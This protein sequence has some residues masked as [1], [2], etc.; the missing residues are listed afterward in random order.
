M[1]TTQ[2]SDL[3]RLVPGFTFAESTSDAGSNILIRG[4]GTNSFSRSVD[5]SVGTVVDNVASG[6]LSGSVLDFSD[7]AAH[8]LDHTYKRRF[9]VSL[10]MDW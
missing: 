9:G 6:S 7:E 2:I 5:L 4:I 3:T 1:N 10:Q 8:I